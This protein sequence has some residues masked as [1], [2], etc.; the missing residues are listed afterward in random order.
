[1]TLTARRLRQ[2]RYTV[3]IANRIPLYGPNPIRLPV[4]R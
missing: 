4:E 3:V 2:G 1:V